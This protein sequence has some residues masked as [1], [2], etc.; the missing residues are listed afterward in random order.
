MRGGAPLPRGEAPSR[1]KRVIR[2]PRPAP[3]S[4]TPSHPDASRP[5]AG[6]VFLVAA[7]LPLLVVARHGQ[8]G[9]ALLR[10]NALPAALLAA[11]DDLVLFLELILFLLSAAVTLGAFIFIY[12]RPS[13]RPRARLHCVP[14][15]GCKSALLY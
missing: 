5:H 1:A 4:H 7:L 13:R 3:R 6:L 14:M 12:D 8:V 2:V 11:R 15:R 10:Q 9:A